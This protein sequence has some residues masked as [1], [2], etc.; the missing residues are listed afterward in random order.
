MFKLYIGELIEPSAM[1]KQDNFKA[2]AKPS[3]NII[4]STSTTEYAHVKISL[5]ALFAITKIVHLYLYFMRVSS[6]KTKDLHPL[7][8]Q[9][10]CIETNV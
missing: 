4:F 7:I 1:S 2:Q 5:L 9:F 8:K 6:K 10:T 3:P